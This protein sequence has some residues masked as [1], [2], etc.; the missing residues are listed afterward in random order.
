MI[1]RYLRMFATV[2]SRTVTDELLEVYFIALKGY[3]LSRIEKGM[4]R[5]LKEGTRWPWPGSL[6]EYID[7]EI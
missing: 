7:E 3:D 1:E 4:R 2:E 6:A 5:Y